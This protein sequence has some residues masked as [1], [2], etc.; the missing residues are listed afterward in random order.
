MC[1]GENSALWYFLIRRGF[2]LSQAS[3]RAKVTIW[4]K[5]IVFIIGNSKILRDYC[6]SKIFLS[7]PYLLVLTYIGRGAR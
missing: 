3:P 2:T 5:L 6:A 1:E 4:Y 7:D